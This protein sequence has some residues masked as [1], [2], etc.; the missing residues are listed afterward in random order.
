[1]IF[2]HDSGQ[3][4]YLGEKN[5]IRPWLANC[6]VYVLP[7]YHEGMPRTILEAM[8]MGRPIITTDAPGCRETVTPGEN[9]YLV[10][11]GSVEELAQRM[12]LF[13]EHP[14][15][16]PAMGAVS[17]RMAESR[18]DVEKINEELMRILNL[19]NIGITP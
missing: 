19:S 15:K 8:A 3:L 9:G 5:D 16:C 18:F 10:A 11:K 17:R 13:I 14:D 4:S 1:M 6:S 2:W 7:S 12:I